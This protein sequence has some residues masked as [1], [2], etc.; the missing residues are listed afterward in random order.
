[1]SLQGK[2]RIVE[3]DA[4]HE[5]DYPDMWS[6]PTSSSAQPAASSPSAASPAPSAGGAGD[7]D[8]VAFDWDGNDEMDEACGDGWA[9]TSGPTD[10]SSAR[11]I[12]HNGDEIPF[13][14]RR[15][16]DF[17]NSLLGRNGRLSRQFLPIILI[18][19]CFCRAPRLL[20]KNYHY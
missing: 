16:R 9:R 18:L 3:M 5:A 1:M 12:F 4:G 7:S 13:I 11:Y 10:R 14:A 15:W 2:W 20:G 8:A 6:P 17:F 19:G